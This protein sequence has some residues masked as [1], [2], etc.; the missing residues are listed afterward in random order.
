MK[1]LK[2]LAALLLAASSFYAGLKVGGNQ[3]IIAPSGNSVVRPLTLTPA[4]NP[5]PEQDTEALKLEIKQLLERLAQETEQRV[6]LAE[7]LQAL[8]RQEPALA[9]IK[10]QISE[11]NYS[12]WNDLEMHDNLQP[13]D[14]LVGILGLSDVQKSELRSASQSF[15][16]NIQSWESQNAKLVKT[17]DGVVRYEVPAPPAHITEGYLQKVK[18]ILDDEEFGIFDRTSNKTLRKLTHAHAIEAEIF[19]QNGVDYVEIRTYKQFREEFVLDGTM[20]TTFQIAPNSTTSSR[21]SH[22]LEFEGQNN[23]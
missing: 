23:E 7:R 3:T 15:L 17:A 1:A 18:T 19:E 6:F 9:W 12:F 5:P 22:L 21:W 13:T 10:N 20:R 16:K 11:G 8:H 2:F 4:P 14:G